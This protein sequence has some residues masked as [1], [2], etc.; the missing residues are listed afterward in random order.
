MSIINDTKCSFSLSGKPG[1]CPVIGEFCLSLYPKGRGEV[2]P[3]AIP[4]IGYLNIF[5]VVHPKKGNAK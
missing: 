5:A 4:G 1:T 3:L 2:K